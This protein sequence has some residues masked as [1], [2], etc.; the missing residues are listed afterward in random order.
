M[1]ASP[2]F[3]ELTSWCRDILDRLAEGLPEPALQRLEAAFLTSSHHELAF[4]DM[5]QEG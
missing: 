3:G 2:E 4:W 1:Y 5:A